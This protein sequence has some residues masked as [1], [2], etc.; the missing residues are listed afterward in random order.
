MINST[1]HAEID[2]QHS[3]LENLMGEL[4]N[5]C[6]E[7]ERNQDASCAEC[8]S[9]I[10][11]A[12]TLASLYS[13]LRAF[14]VGHNAYEERLMELL[15]DSPKCQAHIKE[16]KRAHDQLSRQ[17]KMFSVQ[18]AEKIPRAEGAMMSRMVSNWL[19]DHLDQLDTSPRTLQRRLADNGLTHSQLVHQARLTKALQL[20]VQ[21][22]VRISEVAHAT[23]F[24]TPA[25]F[26][27]AFQSWTG[28]SPRTFRKNL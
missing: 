2:Q 16:H 20:L 7:K 21:Q 14:I 6:S 1:G 19:G 5:F 9:Q 10:G 22:N 8:C 27:R 23:G 12:S 3:I 26:S 11:C 28:S 4:E 18:L 15:P 17:L 13:E 25:G 24:A